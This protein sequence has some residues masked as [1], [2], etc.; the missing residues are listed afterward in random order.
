M[1]A[2][3]IVKVTL[4]VSA[5]WAVSQNAENAIQHTIQQNMECVGPRTLEAREKLTELLRLTEAENANLNQ[6]AGEQNTELV[7]QLRL[8]AIEK[9]KARNMIDNRSD[10]EPPQVIISLHTLL[11]EKNKHKDHRVTIAAYLVSHM[12]GR[13]ICAENGDSKKRLLTTLS[14]RSSDNTKFK[15][16]P[17]MR[18][19]LVAKYGEQG[20]NKDLPEYVGELEGWGTGGFENGIPALITG[21]FKVGDYKLSNSVLLKDHPYIVLTEVSEVEPNNPQWNAAQAKGEGGA[22][23]PAT[24]PQSKPSHD[25]TP[26]PESKPRPQ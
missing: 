15:V 13:W 14:M 1:K 21:I 19:R 7:E 6:A 4:L 9:A 18:S 2:L 26:N 24:A 17:A 10:V 11:D 23:Q 22:D 16:T 5:S 8:E 20:I 25:S 3:Y 12:E